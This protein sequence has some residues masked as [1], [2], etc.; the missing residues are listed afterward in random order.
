M[1]Y[2]SNVSYLK[3]AFKS[4]HLRTIST[5][6]II[7]FCA[8]FNLIALRLEHTVSCNLIVTWLLIRRDGNLDETSCL[9][10][11]REAWQAQSPCRI[12]I[13]TETL[14]SDVNVSIWSNDCWFKTT[15]VKYGI[16]ITLRNYS[17][18]FF[19]V[20][21]H[22]ETWNKPSWNGI[23][24]SLASYCDFFSCQLRVIELVIIYRQRALKQIRSRTQDAKIWRWA[25][26]ES[27]FVEHHIYSSTDVIPFGDVDWDQPTFNER[28]CRRRRE[29]ESHRI[30]RRIIT[31]NIWRGSNLELISLSTRD[32][33]Q[34]RYG[35]NDRKALQSSKSSN[36][37]FLSFL[38]T[39]MHWS[40]FLHQNNVLYK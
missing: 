15:R 9:E 25:G 17:E 39:V 10:W 35:K 12:F 16:N 36:F 28:C 37:A 38:L 6:G 29:G 34:E 26:V 40:Y 33:Y 5:Y 11:H 32:G 13:D 22:T 4:D 24:E 30:L 7:I 8:V 3:A 2:G 18:G 1:W 20:E 21:Q 27:V 19:I 23:V 14:W 31:E